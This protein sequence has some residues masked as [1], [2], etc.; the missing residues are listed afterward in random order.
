MMLELT[1]DRRAPLARLV[2]AWA[3][4]RA[5]EAAERGPA[6][7]RA[8]E[9]VDVE[10]VEV[11][12]SGRPALLDVLAK[13]DGRSVH[14]VLGVRSGE[15][16]QATAPAAEDGLG[17]LQDDDGLAVVIDA[18]RDAQL[19]PLVLEAVTGES[20]ARE[21]AVV[22]SDDEDATVLEFDDC[23]LTVFSSLTSGPDPAVELLLALDEAGFNHLAAPLAVWR[24]RGHD[25]GVVQELLAGSAG[26]WALALTSLRDLYGSGGPPEEAGGDFG[27]EA[28][29]LGTMTARMHLALDRAFGRHEVPVAGW[30]EQV[31]AMVEEL[32]PALLD[33]PSAAA[34]LEAVVGSAD[35][36]VE[37]RTH[38]DFHLGRTAR[39]DLGWVVSD[40]RPGGQPP[41]A[42]QPTLRSPL[43]DVADMLWSM[44]H[45]S[46]V[47]ATER[48]ATGR[49]GLAPLAQAWASR[50]RFA[51]LE[52]YLAQPGIED[53][54]SH[55]RA[56]VRRLVALFELERAVLTGG[57]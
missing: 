38:G 19:A 16:G 52:A 30:G 9:E 41:G 53:L 21:S 6:E 46:T 49:A 17:L 42:T 4:R 26:G 56:T 27:P 5:A 13:V 25:L 3:T 22:V 2:A 18:A 24:R 14:A 37:L 28:Q 47:A 34:A 12:R 51:F 40:C 39:T 20:S 55:D 57:H 36:G 54:V 15:G 8:A 33:D 50:N 1:E 7:R 29:A 10:E 43:A 48:D 45:V 44:H 35:V 32:A 11:L 23:S 31:G